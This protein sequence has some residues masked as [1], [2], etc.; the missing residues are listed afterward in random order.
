MEDVAKYVERIIVMNKGE[1]VYDD[2]PKTIFRHYKELEKIGL[3]AP[4]VTYIMNDLK[5]AGFR[6]DTDAITVEEA[7]D[8]ILKALKM[9]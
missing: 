9:R 6:V 2:A 8:S 4:E 1:L 5:K 3:A 7:R